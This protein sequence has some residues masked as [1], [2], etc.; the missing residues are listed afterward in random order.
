MG[1]YELK[2]PPKERQQRY[3][4]VQHRQGGRLVADGGVDAL[5]EAG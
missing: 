2:F 3:E 5:S 1:R 4:L